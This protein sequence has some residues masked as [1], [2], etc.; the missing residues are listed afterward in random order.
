MKKIL[1]SLLPGKGG[2]PVRLGIRSLPLVL[3]SPLL[4]SK[5]VLP[6]TDDSDPHYLG[7]HTVPV[8]L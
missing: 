1:P 6:S 7:I 4:I 2:A 5:K 3:P 8:F